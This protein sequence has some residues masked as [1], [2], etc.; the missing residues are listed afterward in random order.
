MGGVRK[1]IVEWPRTVAF[2]YNRPK[3]ICE[4][5]ATHP[6]AVGAP[7]CAGL[8]GAFLPPGALGGG[9]LGVAAGTLQNLVCMP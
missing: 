8:P 1:D 2:V 6:V 7:P 9:V 3:Q 4:S 5:S